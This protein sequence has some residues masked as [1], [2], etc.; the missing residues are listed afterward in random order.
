MNAIAGTLQGENNM[1]VSADE[2]YAVLA[3]KIHSLTERN[4]TL[5]AVIVS[6]KWDEGNVEACIV[7]R[8]PLPEP[9]ED[10]KDG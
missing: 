10:Q 6:A 7:A 2:G 8:M 5:K 4:K 9:Y 1:C 3:D